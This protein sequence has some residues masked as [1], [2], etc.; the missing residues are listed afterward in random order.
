MRLEG[1]TALVTGA[2]RGIGAAVARLFAAEGANV[3]LGDVLA[4]QAHQVVA[5]ISDA[6]GT[7]M[8]VEFDVSDAPEWE[9][10]VDMVVDRF[11]TLDILV[12][13]A[14]IY[15]RHTVEELDLETWKRVMEVNAEGVFLGT[16]A[17]IP[18]MRKSGGGSIVNLAS[19]ASM[20][21]SSWATAYNASKAAV[22]NLTRS[23]AI[24]Y[25]QF[26]IRANSI[27]P[28]AIDTAM[29]DQVFIDQEA[30]E[31]HA[32][33]SPLRRDG[34][35]EDVAKAI[36]FLASD[37]ASYVTSAELRVDGGALA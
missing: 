8:V 4:D 9:R 26:G 7:A 5:E 11:G 35:P 30:R 6:G 20:R 33:E 23:T 14:G 37:D 27:H 36:L 21:G 19:I 1:K 28:G 22:A 18:A 12:N 31:K 2:A 17:C 13:N 24:Q 25:G 29:L 34:T 16:K 10:A 32:V 15:E 3:A